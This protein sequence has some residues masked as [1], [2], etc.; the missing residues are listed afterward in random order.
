[1]LWPCL[2]I[3]REIFEERTEVARGEVSMVYARSGTRF[4]AI[5][6][7]DE[8]EDGEE[9]AW[10]IGPHSKQVVNLTWAKEELNLK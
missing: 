7:I 9:K 1:M 6:M 3:H 5:V 4:T 10:M 2:L 8:N